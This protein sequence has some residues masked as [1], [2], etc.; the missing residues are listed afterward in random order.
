MLRTQIARL[1]TTLRRYNL[2]PHRIEILALFPILAIAT[3]AL[4]NRSV[5][6]LTGIVLPALLIVDAIGRAM[7]RRPVPGEITSVD[8]MTGLPTRPALDHALAEVAASDGR[9]TT[10]CLFIRIDGHEHLAQRWGADARDEILRRTAERLQTVIRT[11]DVAARVEDGTFGLVLRPKP[12]GRPDQPEA[13]AQRVANALG[14]PL[15]IAGSTALVTISIGIAVPGELGINDLARGAEAAVAEAQ[16]TRKGSIRSF[17]RDLQERL[18]RDIELVRA[19]DNGLTTGEIRA[20]Y[21][22]QVCTDSGQ[23]TGFEALARWHHPTLG[24]LSPGQFLDAI[25]NAGCMPRLSEVMLQNALSALASWDRKGLKI[26]TVSVNFS[27]EELRDPRLADRV[28]WEVDRF[29]IRPARVTI[30]ILESV[31]ALGHDD[32]I[33]GNIDQFANHGFNLDLDDFGTGQA[34]IQ[35]IRRFRVQRIKIDRSFVTAIDTDPEQQSIVAAIL[36]LAQHLGVE[37]LA[38]GVETPGEHSI[39]AQLGCGNVQGF[40][41][42]RPMPFEDTFAWID[43]HRARSAPTPL[44]GRN[45]G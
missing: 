29:D 20:W 23:I 2:S 10:A 4:S 8:A 44:I 35:N 16:K 36:S 45:T 11:E 33:L 31:A 13:L 25:A 34:S 24:T 6:E 26:P 9:L 41:V 14:E 42:A 39:L 3:A 43:G 27:P 15:H 38:E 17:S 19:V 30:E 18:S 7:T 37:T 28:K 22:P 5:A 1:S 40:G 12:A 32:A 21:Q